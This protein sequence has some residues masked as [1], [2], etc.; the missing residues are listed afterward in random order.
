MRTLLATLILI[1]SLLVLAEVRYRGA[2]VVLRD[3]D[4]QAFSAERA[5]DAITPFVTSPHPTGSP[6]LAAARLHVATRLRALGL[7]PEERS[8]LVCGRFGVCARVQQIAA[9]IRGNGSTGVVLIMAHLDA[10]GAS[11][12]ASDDGAGAGSLLEIARALTAGS[13]LRNDVVVLFVEGEELGLLGAEA[14]AREDPIAREVRVVV[15]LEARGTRGSASLFQISRDSQFVIDAARTLPRPIGSSLFASIYERMPNDTDLSVFLPRGY[16]GMNFAFTDG[17]ESYHTAHDDLAHQDPRSMQHLGE[18]GLAAVR[19]LAAIDLNNPRRGD[20]VF[21]D[22]LGFAIVGYPMTWALPLALIALGLLTAVA[23]IAIRRGKTTFFALGVGVAGWLLTV[24][25]AA[26]FGVAVYAC[27]NAAGALPAPWIAQPGALLFALVAAALTATLTALASLRRLATAES[28]A[29]AVALVHG[30]LGVVIARVLPG[31]SYLL[32]VPSLVAAVSAVLVLAARVHPRA[33]IATTAIVQVTLWIVVVRSLYPV[34]GAMAAPGIAVLVALVVLPA[35]PLLLGVASALARPFALALGLF[36]VVAAGFA[37]FARPFT[38][39]APQRVN[40]VV[41]K[42]EGE[43]A[44]VGIDPT[45]GGQPW[46]GAP[47]AMVAALGPSRVEAI[48]PW[49]DD[50]YPVGDVT[51]DAPA[52]EVTFLERS[53]RRWRLR[54]RTVRNA[55]SIYVIGMPGAGLAHVEVASAVGAATFFR[56]SITPGARGVR[57]DGVP[58]LEVVLSFGGAPGVVFIGDATYGIPE[59][60]RAVIAARPAEAVPTQDGDVTIAYRSIR[61]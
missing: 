26:V 39:G 36:T 14:F 12:G 25:L 38:G 33:A 29:L 35:A 54:I 58:E 23:L 42:R 43:S 60:A 52:P 24:V 22:V 51:V 18:S 6:A 59:A 53:D 32:V 55:S 49:R 13:T 47:A 4:A 28:F 50:A 56:R 46:G 45:W 8:T 41:A 3:G 15:N 37:A 57:I 34:L 48:V 5:R 31:G 16:A 11:M 20:A 17:V 1:C 30:L 61:P 19:A 21:F 44:R 10:V 2:P 7:A 9:R 27:V 40:V